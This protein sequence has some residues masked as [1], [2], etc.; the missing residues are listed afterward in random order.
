MTLGYMI[1]VFL[2]R[3]TPSVLEFKNVGL[4]YIKSY[5]CKDCGGRIRVDWQRTMP[6]I[7]GKTVRAHCRGCGQPHIVTG[8][9]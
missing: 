2:L 9:P 6:G 5:D 4:P 3:K 1:Y 8:V 7:G